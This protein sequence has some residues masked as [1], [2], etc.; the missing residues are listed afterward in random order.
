MT[1][2]SS[3][4][5]ELAQ[6]IC[7]LIAEGNSLVQICQLDDM[8]HRATI[9][10]WLNAKPDFAARCDRAR[11]EQGDFLFDDIARVEAKL[12]SGEMASDVART[13]ISSKQWRS[14]K[15]APKR[16]GDK[17]AVETTATVKLESTRRL[18]ISTLS[19]DELD[20]FE[21]VLRATVAQMEGPLL[22][23]DDD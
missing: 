8:P 10:R 3:Y 14:A 20:A 16:Y 2:P 6:T 9:L 13:L 18:N 1:R 21:R 4:S 11:L 22:E 23:H 12:E 17:T 19:D 7:D 15:L 5:E